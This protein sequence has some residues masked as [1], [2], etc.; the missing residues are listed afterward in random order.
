MA[1]KKMKAA[2]K[3]TF[4]EAKWDDIINCAQ[5]D[6]N[7]RLWSIPVDTSIVPST[8]FQENFNWLGRNL[9]FVT[10]AECR[11]AI[12]T[13]IFDV[14]D[15]FP[16]LMLA[17]EYTISVT[18]DDETHELHGRLDYGVC[19][20]GRR[21]LPHLAV[22]EAKE[23]TKTGIIQCVAQ[24]AAIYQQRKASSAHKN[25][26]VFGIY[27]NG[28]V[29]TFICIDQAGHY[30]R[31]KPITM[32]L[33]AYDEQ[34]LYVYRLVYYIIHSAHEQSPQSTNALDAPQ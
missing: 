14:V 25:H 32:S 5:V 33:I 1:Q 26:R 17:L 7:E 12:D 3:V 30:Y 24:C 18:N 2:H 34:V 15:K 20:H 16:N 8:V 23:E 28:Q 11:A 21:Y 27:T 10:E 22:V 29:W 9:E 4:K 31:T 19:H 13:I 6:P